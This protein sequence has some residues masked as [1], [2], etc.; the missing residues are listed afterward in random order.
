MINKEVQALARQ[1]V[2]DLAVQE[3]GS[4]EQTFL[5]ATRNDISITEVLAIGSHLACV[6]VADGVVV[7][8]Y[9]VKGVKPAT[10]ISPEEM[11]IAPYGGINYMGIEID[12]IVS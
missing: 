6:D 11:V 7:N 2:L 9:V 5:L 10:E 3:S 4:V 8:R 12:F 1:S